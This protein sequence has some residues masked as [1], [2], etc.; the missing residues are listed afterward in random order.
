[1][2]F[3]V[4]SGIIFV[5]YQTSTCEIKHFRTSGKGTTSLPVYQFFSC[6]IKQLIKNIQTRIWLF[7]KRKLLQGEERTIGRK[8]PGMKFGGGP[9]LR[10]KRRRFASQGLA[11]ET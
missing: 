4:N 8:Q 10:S 1:M 7:C 6:G 3:R 9:L 11:Y 2:I 5:Q